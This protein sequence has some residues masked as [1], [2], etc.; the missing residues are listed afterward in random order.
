MEALPIS[1]LADIVSASSM[2]DE[3][4][5]VLLELLF[6][7]LGTNAEWEDASLRSESA[8][9]LKKHNT[10]LQKRYEEGVCVCVCVCVCGGRGVCYV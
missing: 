5:Q 8:K 7:K 2:S 4:I 9:T 3:D 6:D 10:E 1:R